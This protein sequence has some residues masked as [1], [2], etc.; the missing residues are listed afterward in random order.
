MNNSGI[1]RRIKTVRVE[2]FM[3]SQEVCGEWANTTKAAVSSWEK[4]RSR[5][6]L[7]ALNNLRMRKGLNPAWVLTGEGQSTLEIRDTTQPEV[8]EMTHFRSR[9]PLLRWDEIING[10]FMRTA[11][12]DNQEYIETTAPITRNTFALTVEGDSMANEFPEGSVIVCEQGPVEPG[13]FVIA[14]K[15]G[16]IT[17]KKLIRDG[18]ILYLAPLNPQYPMIPAEGY[19]MLARVVQSI[20]RYE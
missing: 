5:P 9:V 19:E 4:G 14:L 7:T 13:H 17:F 3:V 1:A 6:G 20:K 10:D 16:F 12:G 18:G 2:E 8:T 11:I 15:D